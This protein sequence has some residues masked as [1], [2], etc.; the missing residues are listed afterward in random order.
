MSISEKGGDSKGQY[1]RLAKARLRV[2]FFNSKTERGIE[3]SG[4][5]AL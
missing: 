3:C 1:E 2:S 5:T 4:K